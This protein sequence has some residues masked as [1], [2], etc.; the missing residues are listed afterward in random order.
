[1]KNKSE[2]QTHYNNGEKPKSLKS[3]KTKKTI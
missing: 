1:M 2:I 3:R